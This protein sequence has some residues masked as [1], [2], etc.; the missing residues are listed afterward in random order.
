MRGLLR[1]I[2][3]IL[4]DKKTVTNFEGDICYAKNIKIR[5]VC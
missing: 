4:S 1:K 2:K 3:R 5:K